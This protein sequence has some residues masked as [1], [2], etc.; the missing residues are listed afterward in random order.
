MSAMLE[1][2]LSDEQRELLAVERGLLAEV[3]AGLERTEE[4]TDDDRRALADSMQQLDELFLIVVVG[5]FNAGKS[6][7]VNALLGEPLLAEGVTPT[8]AK[9][10]LL[11]WGETRSRQPLGA[12]AERITAPLDA[13]RDLSFVDTP[14]TNALDRVHEALTTDFVP[15][16]DLVLF[17]TSA[18]RPLSESE[19]QFLESIA[20]WGKKLVLLVNKVDILRGEAELNEVLGYVRANAGRILGLSLEVLPIS[21]QRAAEARARG[22]AGQLAASGLPGVESF[23]RDR[24]DRGERLRL[25]L[26]NPLGVASRLLG[27]ALAANQDRRGLLGDDQR[28]VAD[29][30]GQTAAWAADVAREFE[31]RLADIDNVL[32]R[33]ERR[34]HDFFDDTVRIERLRRLFDRE[35]LQATF[36]AAV[37]GDAPAEIEARVAALIDWLVDSELGYWQSVVNHVNRRAAAHAD[38]MVGEVGGRFQSDR[39]RLLDTVGRAARSSLAAYDRTAESRRM[40]A[41]LQKAVTSAAAL[42]VGAV[43]LGAAVA[44]AASSTAA[45]VTGFTA[46]GLLAVL[47]LFVLP[48]RRRRAKAAFSATMAA[49]RARLMEALRAHFATEVEERRQRLAATVAP[50][51]R[52]V[53]AESERLTAER[54]ML[55]DLSTRVDELQARVAAPA[56]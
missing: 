11:T 6:A 42:E 28:T 32:H 25:K 44:L 4:A 35:A 5:E 18:D 54:D 22:D 41:D 16:A 40:A 56:A 15:R 37:V 14:G 10:H 47:G 45:D 36:D 2:I 43:G 13:L 12:A 8:T 34:G 17:V 3:A 46:A 20:A 26:G 50:Y 31:L 48:H 24:L 30:E 49:L 51:T 23:L 53:R 27:R 19:R 38:R 33:M 52:F 55:H 9:L 21:A 1:P 29:I 39:A 7:F